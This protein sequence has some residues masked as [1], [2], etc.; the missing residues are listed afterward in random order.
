MV[1][2]MVVRVAENDTRDDAVEELVVICLGRA[3]EV[4]HG[5]GDLGVVGGEPQPSGRRVLGEQRLQPLLEDGR[6]AR[7]QHL[8]AAGVDRGR[9]KELGRSARLFRQTEAEADRLS[10]WLLAGAGYDPEAAARFW[11]KFGRRKGRRLARARSS[12]GLMRS[13]A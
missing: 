8:D 3:G 1:A 5:F 10:V 12:K 13:T 2:Q 11:R 6:A 4:S 7:V 9:F